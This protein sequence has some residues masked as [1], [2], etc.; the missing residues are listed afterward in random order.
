MYWQRYGQLVLGMQISGLEEEF[1]L[2]AE[3]PRLLY[4]KGPAPEREPRLADLLARIKD[5]RWCP[6]ATSALQP[7]WV[8]WFVMT[9]P[10]C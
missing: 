10:S 5:R 6:T 1:E 8:G 9:W 3:L 7:N 2:S 4:V